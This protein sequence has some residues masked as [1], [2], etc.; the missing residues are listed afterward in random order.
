M[1][2]RFIIRIIATEEFAHT[3][4]PDHTNYRHIWS[5]SIRRAAMDDDFPI[6]VHIRH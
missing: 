3:N 4:L 1:D 5:G 6:P 2:G